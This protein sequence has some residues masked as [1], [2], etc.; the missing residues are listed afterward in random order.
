LREVKKEFEKP[1]HPKLFHNY[2][3]FLDKYEL[4]FDTVSE[5]AGCFSY[6]IWLL[7]RK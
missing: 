3:Q 2:N 5:H 4:V 6:F 7:K 1:E